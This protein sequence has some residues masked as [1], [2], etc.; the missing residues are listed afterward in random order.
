VVRWLLCAGIVTFVAALWPA[1]SQAQVD[2]DYWKGTAARQDTVNRL[3]Y[4]Q[5]PQTIPS[6]YD[7]VAEAEGYL[8]EAQRDL[9]S[10]NPEAPALWQ[11]IR[12]LTV[13]SALST[14]PRALGTIGLAAGAFEL[15][16]KIGSGIN[17]KFLRIGLPDPPEP[18]ASPAEGSLDFV[19][20]GYASVFNDTPLQARLPRGNRSDGNWRAEPGHRVPGVRRTLEGARGRVP[21]SVHRPR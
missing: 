19:T 3:I 8:R 5:S 14:A 17:A 10:S 7:P 13:R 6:G 1:A 2:S 11:E 15:G 4:S 20:A 12:G 16:W 9:P 18:K 21:D